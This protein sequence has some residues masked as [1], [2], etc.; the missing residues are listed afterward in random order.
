MAQV[1]S[2]LFDVNSGLLQLVQMSHSSLVTFEQH[3]PGRRYLA[4]GH[5]TYHVSIRS[6]RK[7]ANVFP[8][9]SNE[10][11]DLL[12]LG[13]ITF[14]DC[15]SHHLVFP[16][17]FVLTGLLSRNKRQARCGRSQLISGYDRWPNQ[18]RV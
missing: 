4:R 11:V 17:V 16:P 7:Q 13:V 1:P 12:R 5:A 15:E 9:V 18:N 8:S 2:G 3:M 6:S 10:P 14:V